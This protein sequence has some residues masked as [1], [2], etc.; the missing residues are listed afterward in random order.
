MVEM[1]EKEDMKA[2]LSKIN[3]LR[4]DVLTK[5]WSDD[6]NFMMGGKVMYPYLSADKVK[7]T[8]APL[9][10]KHGLELVMNFT[11]LTERA[12]VGGFKQHWSIKLEA[13][14]VDVDTGAE[15]TNTVYGEA[16]DVGDKGINKAQ[17]AAIKQWIMSQ[18]LIADGID[19]EGDSPMTSSKFVP[20][21]R[22]ETEEVKSQVLAQ[23]VKPAP[24]PPA[25]APKPKA[26]A[27][28]AP[29]APPVKQAEAIGAPQ[30]KAMEK[31]VTNI[32][33]QVNAGTFDPEEFAQ[34]EGEHQSVTTSAEAIEFIKKY[35]GKTQ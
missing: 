31:I 17:T 26:E 1:N 32:R 20:K 29:V 22:E 34:I 15:V 28:K 8:I 6:K 16:G 2:L 4:A 21:T 9:F 3:A 5:D 10:H 25:P 13:T 27:P 35:R 7:K 11:D 33:E 12:E 18:F 14:L 24:A 30:Q 23:T 19:P